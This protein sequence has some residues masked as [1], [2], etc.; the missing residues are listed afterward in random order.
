[1][2]EP[3][4]PTNVGR[5]IGITHR[6]K[7]TVEGESRPTIV[8][9]R[10]PDG[11]TYRIELNNE[12]EELDFVLGQFPV[13]HRK[14]E[15]GE[16]ATK[17]RQWHL[18]KSSKAK[19]AEVT[20][21]PADFDGLRANDTVVL[22]FGGSGDYLAFGICTQADV[23]GATV[24]RIAPFHLAQMRG[25]RS[26]DDD[27]SLLVEMYYTSPDRFSSVRPRDKAITL[28]RVTVRRFLEVQRERIAAGNRF[29]QAFYGRAFT[30]ANLDPS[31]DITEAC[32]RAEKKDAGMCKLEADE[33]SAIAAVTSALRGCDVY[34]AL[35]DPIEGVGP[36][37]GGRIITAIG[38]VSRFPTKYKLRKFCGVA[39]GNDG[40]FLRRRKGQTS[41]W[42]PQARQGLWHLGDQM[43]RRP[44]SV[45]G[46]RLISNLEKMR[47]KHPHPVVVVSTG[48][49]KGEYPLDGVI[50]RR[51][52]T[53][54]K[55]ELAVGD[56]WVKISGITRYGPL[57]LRKQALWRTLTDFTDWV[58]DQWWNIEEGKPVIEA[59]DWFKVDVAPDVVPD[60]AAAVE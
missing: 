40:T 47:T 54:S 27:A 43:N 20:H 48:D 29:R 51:V 34:Q 35:F 25:E 42:N 50:A 6:V 60:A 14:V 36:S 7:A 3:T 41:N 12:Q 44:G 24:K 33:K 18:K 4:H 53:A 5:I 30:L 49:H 39:V 21:V 16:D 2:S 37:I 32:N 11:H 46:T 15:P 26:K 58:Y 9:I 56:A 55:Y 17:F 10:N 38:D 19:D 13:K 57:H 31:I 28:A 59:D 22:M 52:G 45:W 8:V 1:M 23:V